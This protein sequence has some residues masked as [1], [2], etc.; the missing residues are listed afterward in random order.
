[1]VKDK[2]ACHAALHGV[3]NSGT[4]LSNWKMT[5]I[6]CM[7]YTFYTKYGLLLYSARNY[8]F[9]KWRTGRH[10]KGDKSEI[11]SKTPVSIVLA[12]HRELCHSDGP[13]SS[14]GWKPRGRVSPSGPKAKREGGDRGW[15]WMASP[16]QWTWVWANWG[17]FSEVEGKSDY[18]RINTELYR[19]NTAEVYFQLWMQRY[20]WRVVKGEDPAGKILWARPTTGVWPFYPHPTS[21]IS[22]VLLLLPVRAGRP[23]R[24]WTQVFLGIL[25][26]T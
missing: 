19:L 13:P 21:P 17:P 23:G 3:T 14:Q 4:W 1:M 2:K 18:I 12:A 11:T 16:S 9:L 6:L 20:R 15:D 8:S 5:S 24:K 25:S 26:G 22:M 7:A 10:M